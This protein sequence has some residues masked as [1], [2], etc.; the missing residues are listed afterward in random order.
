MSDVNSDL[1]AVYSYGAAVLCCVV[2]HVSIP[3]TLLLLYVLLCVSL[4]CWLLFWRT[5]YCKYGDI[6]LSDYVVDWGL[7]GQYALDWTARVSFSLVVGECWTN[8]G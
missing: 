1:C 3:R 4:T 2:V 8:T 7:T 5:A 6:P